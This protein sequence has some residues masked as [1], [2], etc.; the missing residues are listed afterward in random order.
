MQLGR[1]V[2]PGFVECPLQFLRGH[3]A[4]CI[5]CAR[6]VNSLE[7]NGQAERSD[8]HGEDQNPTVRVL[9]FGRFNFDSQ[10]V[11][12]PGYSSARLF[13]RIGAYHASW[14]SIRDTKDNRPAALV[15]ERRTI[16]CQLFEME[17]ASRF[18]EL[19]ALSFGFN[20]EL[21]KSGERGVLIVIRHSGICLGVGF[22]AA[23]HRALSD[24]VVILAGV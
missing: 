18:L 13:K 16:L 23:M 17:P 14:A 24:P 9:H 21:L 12:Q 6:P 19:Q 3:W 10:A 8:R 5:A 22:G 1:E 2:R 7:L 20:D 11:G 4:Q 15:R